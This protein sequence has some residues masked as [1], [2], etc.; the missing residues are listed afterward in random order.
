MRAS[1]DLGSASE[2]KERVPVFS[3]ETWLEKESCVVLCMFDGSNVYSILYSEVMAS[4][5]AGTIA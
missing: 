4:I 3:I 1:H 2:E 5:S